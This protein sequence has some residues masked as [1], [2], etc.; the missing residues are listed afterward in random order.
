M[1][2]VDAT[3][4]VAALARLD[5]GFFLR[6]SFDEL[7]GQDSYSHNWHIDAI[8]RQLDLIRVGENR[9]LIV[10]MP[11]RHLKSRMISI[12]WVAW[13]LGHNPALSFLCVS[14]GQELSEDYA[15]DCLKIM[16]SRWYRVAFPST[17]ITR[18]AVADIRTSA[19]GRR[20]ATSVDGKTT[21]FGADIIIVDDPMKS[22]DAM[23]QDAR[24]KVT[25]WF[26]DTLS[27]RLNNQLHGSI[28]VVMQRL[29]EGDLVGIL[30]ER[31][32]WR[33]LCLPA[34]ATRDEDIPLTR[35]RI[36]RRREGCA[37]HP[38]R[39][40]VSELLTKRAANPYVFASQF[41]Q[42]PVPA[43][44]NMIEAGWLQ[45]Y[46]LATIDLSRGQIVMS[47]DT[48]SKDNPFN[49]YSVSVVALVVGKR[50]YV[51]DVF[52]ARLQF[53]PLKAKV[54]ELARLHRANVLLIED[55]SSG[56]ALIQSLDDEQPTGVPSPIRRR[57]EGDKIARV[58]NV[59]AMI[60]A[61]RLFLPENAHWL[62]DFTGELLGFP[63][64][65]HDDQV[66][67]ISQL[68]I[69]VQERDRWRAPLLAG[70]ELMSL[71]PPFAPGRNFY[72]EFDPWSGL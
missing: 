28:I 59:S 24:E 21:G 66:D 57:P 58:M 9:R 68:L 25:R 27:Q 8:I 34:I 33:E 37:L 45:K 69:W 31:E 61:G 41:Q 55:A 50:V 38:A 11:P 32:T 5:F 35:G 15:S 51:I 46:N 36:Y 30:K 6:R 4:A 62:G 7:G 54:I 2:D 1:A 42:E 39:L 70:P 23:S 40:P 63:S 60:M 56:T 18:S 64:S 44:G 52:R 29:H 17:V 47:L 71:G 65:R 12:A 16:Q 22:Q 49:D 48:A 72:D 67:A 3:D 10:T 53:N 43:H 20:M 19:G 14:Y 26:D 13:M